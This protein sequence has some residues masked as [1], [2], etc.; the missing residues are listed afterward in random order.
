MEPRK[1]ITWL[2]PGSDGEDDNDP[3]YDSEAAQETK[4]H[5][6]GQPN[7][8]RK[9]DVVDG[10]DDGGDDDEDKD[11]VHGEDGDEGEGEDVGDHIVEEGRTALGQSIGAQR[12]SL[13]KDADVFNPTQ[14]DDDLGP[15]CQPALKPLTAKELAAA[16]RAVRR[17]GV[18]YLSRVPPFMKPTKVRSLLSRFGTVNR[19]FL[20]PEDP[21][22]HSARVR[23]G[24]NKKRSFTD[25][26]VEFAAKKDAKAVAESLNASIIG[27]KKGGYYHDDVWNIKY[28]K[29][30]KWH[31][32]TE[33][34]ANENAERAARMRNEIA[35]AR[36][37]DREFVRNVERAKML[38]GMGRQRNA[39]RAAARDG[40]GGGEEPGEGRARR[41]TP[42]HFT[43][44]KV[45]ARHRGPS[46]LGE[47]PEA[48]RRVLSKIF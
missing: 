4:G 39:R 45:H 30:F 24:G 40:G 44:N 18:V 20:S 10:Q 7:K 34:I 17:T 38:E 47:Q 13:S 21:A 1:R 11:A 26:W 33:Q 42:R 3:G 35:H 2:E 8:R 5:R 48:V 19:I 29:G 12:T 9:L 43:Q 16:R 31:H 41:D 27:G 32:L 15:T 14:T 25:G 28:L 6:R 46:D 22:K 37:E 36:K 23:S